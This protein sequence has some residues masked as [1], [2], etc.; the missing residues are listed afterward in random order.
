MRRE[1]TLHQQLKLLYAKSA[2]RR[3]VR[4]GDYRV[5]AISRGT[6][7]EIQQSGLS[8]I[9]HKI[10]TLLQDHRVLV[11]KPIVATR[12]LRTRQNAQSEYAAPRKSPYRGSWL[13]A[14]DELMHLFRVFPHPQLKI[15]LLLVDIEEDRTRK[16]R[17]RFRRAD[18]VV[19]DRR[20]LQIR[21]RCLLRTPADLEQ[22]VPPFP[23][24]PFTTAELALAWNV[25]RWTAQ[26]IAWCFRTVGAWAPVG[27]SK[28]SVLY[29]P[30]AA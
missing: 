24:A 8:A 15:E 10:Q 28:R 1:S 16:A 17:Y 3:E 25:P 4:V 12:M 14:F 6:L 21:E 7:I 13:D 19:D 11:V 20:L 9:R 2:E 29:L 5:D 30:H 23:A 22:L 26:K 27:F 18:H